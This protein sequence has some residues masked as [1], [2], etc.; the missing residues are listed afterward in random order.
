MYWMHGQQSGVN[1]SN[2]WQHAFPEHCSASRE[3]MQLI[4]VTFLSMT[5]KTSLTTDDSGVLLNILQHL[6]LPVLLPHACMHA[7]A[8]LCMD[9][10]GHSWES[11][12][13]QA[14]S[15]FASIVFDP[16]Q[17]C[18]TSWSCSE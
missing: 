1:R 8:M 9:A 15:L 7:Y 16:M 17:G 3:R 14:R 2:A 4:P 5:N 12:L 13:P 18:M 11:L 6:T 10:D